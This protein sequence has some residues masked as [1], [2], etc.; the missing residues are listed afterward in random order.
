MS[1]FFCVFKW[2]LFAVFAFAECRRKQSSCLKLSSHECIPAIAWVNSCF[3]M[4]K[5][6]CA[7]SPLSF[8]DTTDSVS[9]FPHRFL[10]IMFIY[11]SIVASKY[12]KENISSSLEQTCR[13]VL[14][15]KVAYF[16]L[17]FFCFGSERQRTMKLT[18]HFA[19]FIPCWLIFLY[20][21]FKNV[22]VGWLWIVFQW[23]VKRNSDS[24]KTKWLY[25][26]MSLGKRVYFNLL[27]DIS[28]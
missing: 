2:K 18:V 21:L 9:R 7:Y 14:W 4:A 25:C 19:D 6:A 8:Q 27:Y 26:V 1:T 16:S 10:Q 23:R 3:L 28:W 15:E 11:F 12:F 22:S 17:F 24:F 5:Y 13:L 20:S